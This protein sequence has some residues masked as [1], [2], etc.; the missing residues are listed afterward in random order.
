MMAGSMLTAM[1]WRE[2]CMLLIRNER[3][4]DLMEL[5]NGLSNNLGVA[6]W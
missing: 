4:T 6:R 5:S 2:K 3:R 1:R